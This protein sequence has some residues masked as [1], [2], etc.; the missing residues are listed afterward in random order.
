MLTNKRNPFTPGYGEI[1]PV[2]A[3]RDQLKLELRDRIDAALEKETHPTA[4][5]L[6]GP[7]GCG[8]T[9]LLGWIAKEAKKKKLPE[10]RLTKQHFT[11]VDNLTIAL[12][13]QADSNLR[14]RAYV[15]RG[16]V[17]GP[18]G[19]LGFA[20]LELTGKSEAKPVVRPIHLANLLAE[21]STGGLAILIDEAHDLPPE[22]GRVF[23]EA[24]HAAAQDYPI[25]LVIAG[26]PDLELVLGRTKSTLVER[27]NIWSI[28][29]LS[30]E[31]TRRALFEPF[32]NDVTFDGHARQ[33]VLQET[34]N[35]PY[36]IQLWGSALWNVMVRKGVTHVGT[37]EVKE[38]RRTFDEVRLSLYYHRIKELEGE[39][40]LVPVAEMV[41]RIGEG[42]KPSALEVE[43]AIQQISQTLDKSEAEE[44]L[45]HTGFVWREGIDNWQFGIPSLA[46]HV[47]KETVSMVLIQIELE[48]ALPSLRKVH[49]C[50]KHA[51]PLPIS[52][53]E[54]NLRTVM[55]ETYQEILAE[56]HL[57][58]FSRMGLIAPDPDHS[59]KHI[60]LATPLLTEAV[61]E[62]AD[63]LE[64][65]PEMESI[66][67]PTLQTRHE[68]DDV[69]P[70]KSW[71]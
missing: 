52:Y 17:E 22:V 63:R 58:T 41:F 50:F 35:Y 13:E 8:K 54:E 26:T 14:S 21:A 18:T 56:L 6:I 57:A 38:A 15:T 49:S 12:A 32:G 44:K 30:V 5:A 24:V 20:G 60:L 55:N 71:N 10:L 70:G 3:G 16:E 45:L 68:P 28:G 36:F 64:S 1:P 27:M 53:L 48:N 40:M 37:V 42:G 31:D 11:S 51:S 23:Y 34:E 62:E 61:I 65:K 66:Q 33:T 19:L 4:I 7:R 67:E 9:A 43:A 47:R 69:S 2:F 29:L 25:L 59:K 39:G 46:T